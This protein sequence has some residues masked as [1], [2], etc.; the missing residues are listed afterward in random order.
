MEIHLLSK[1]MSFVK[2]LK[3]SALLGFLQV[4]TTGQ[5]TGHDRAG[6]VPAWCRMVDMWGL[7]AAQ[8]WSREQYTWGIRLRG[9]T[10]AP[11][12]EG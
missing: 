7:L 3:Y 12:T 2:G 4:W 11:I 8:Q 9:Y 1:L 6:A 10:V 5:R